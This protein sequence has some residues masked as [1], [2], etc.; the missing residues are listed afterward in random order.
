MGSVRLLM[1]AADE[2]EAARLRSAVRRHVQRAALRS[3]LR[4]DKLDWDRLGMD[5]ATLWKTLLSKPPAGAPAP[6]SLRDLD[7]KE[8]TPLAV[9]G[10]KAHVLFFLTTDCPIANAYAP[11]INAIVKEFAGRPV[12]FYAV[13]VDPDLTPEAARQHAR[14]FGLRLPV[15]VDSKHQLVSAVGATRTPE[16]AVLA[17]GGKVV[18]RGLIDN[19]FPA[20]GK[21]RP[22]P[23][24]RDLRDALAA[25]LAG[26][27]VAV[28]RTEAVGCSIPDLPGR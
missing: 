17:P 14:D 12:R 7:G 6:V 18:Y 10:A 4:G 21:K 27:R 2:A 11:A 5:R 28:A 22:A 26:E 8:Q 9:T 20:L 24:R 23:T 3:Q 19:R 1:V 16:V 15:V 25:V 13:Q